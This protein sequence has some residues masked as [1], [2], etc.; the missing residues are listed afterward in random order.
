MRRV[1]AVLAMRLDPR[2]TRRLK[3]ARSEGFS[4]RAAWHEAGKLSR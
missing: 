4:W 1:L 2:M 3:Y